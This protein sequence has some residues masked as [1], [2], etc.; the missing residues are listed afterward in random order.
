MQIK[1]LICLYIKHKHINQKNLKIFLEYLPYSFTIS[2]PHTV[3]IL[4]RFDI[5]YAFHPK[6]PKCNFE[7]LN[8]RLWSGTG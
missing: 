1:F 4:F 7:D 8:V 6:M 3:K 5:W 2:I